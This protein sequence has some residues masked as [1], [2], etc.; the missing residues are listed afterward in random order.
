MLGWN[1]GLRLFISGEQRN[2]S[3]KNEVN[4]VTRAVLGN[5]EHSKSSNSPPTLGGP[6]CSLFIY[7]PFSANCHGK[8]DS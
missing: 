1:R 2:K 7:F 5:R 3:L 8:N 6:Q 4:S